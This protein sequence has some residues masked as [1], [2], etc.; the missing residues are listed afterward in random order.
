MSEWQVFAPLSRHAYEALKRDIARRGIKVPIE[1]DENGEVLDGNTRMQIAEELG[2]TDYPTVVR[3][4]SSDLERKLHVIAL[5]THRRHM[6]TPKWRSWVNEYEQLAMEVGIVPEPTYQDDDGVVVPIRKPTPSTSAI[7]ATERQ[8]HHRLRERLRPLVA[9]HADDD[10]W[11]MAYSC[12]VITATI[13]RG[14]GHPAL[15]TKLDELD[16]LIR[17]IAWGPE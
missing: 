6:A 4:F 8:R 11:E 7:H 2:I 14:I 5:N 17:Q 1:M 10:P 9:R 12:L 16:E 3:S 13:R 15:L